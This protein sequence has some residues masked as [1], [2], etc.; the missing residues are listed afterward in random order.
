VREGSSGPTP[1]WRLGRRADLQA[2]LDASR[3][4]PVHVYEQVVAAHLR[5]AT[6][7]L[8]PTLRIPVRLVW[9]EQDACCTRSSPG[10]CATASP[11]PS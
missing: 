8:L 4:M 9:G 7:P 11:A 1:S 5:T 3:T 10:A 2:H 6:E